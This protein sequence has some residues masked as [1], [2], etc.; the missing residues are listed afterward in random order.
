MSVAPGVPPA[1]ANDRPTHPSRTRACVALGLLV[2]L[3]LQTGV[4][5]MTP[6]DGWAEHRASMKALRHGA[7]TVS[8]PGQVAKP[9]V[10]AKGEIDPN[11]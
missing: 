4:A 7:V 8:A 10:N 9:G 6:R 2:A 5:L 3:L 11:C 1:S